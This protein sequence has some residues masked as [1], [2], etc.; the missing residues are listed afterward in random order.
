M[1]PQMYYVVDGTNIITREQS[2]E[3]AEFFASRMA[4]ELGHD[5]YVL[6]EI[7]KFEP[8]KAIRTDLT[9]DSQ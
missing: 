4:V 8:P 9:G 3:S 5:I 7:T 6:L 1:R 2:R